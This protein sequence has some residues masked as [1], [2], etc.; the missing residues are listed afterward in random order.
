VGWDMPGTYDPLHRL[1]GWALLGH[2]VS[3]HLL[4]HPDETLLSD[5]R[6]VL[7]AIIYY[8]LPHPF[9]ALKWNPGGGIHD[10]FDITSDAKNHLGESFL[11]VS[12][13]HEL[14][15]IEKSFAEV[16]SVGRISINL[17]GGTT[18]DFL[19][20]ELRGFKGY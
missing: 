7:A 6:E 1:R 11:L 14:G 9:G 4:Q 15:V 19:V 5:N 2:S 8:G 20:A 17:G 12:P 10:Q 16:G 13:R 18:R 3:A